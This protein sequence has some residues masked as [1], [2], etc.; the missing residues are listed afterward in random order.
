[1]SPLLIGSVVAIIGGSVGPL[2]GF[3]MN[4]ARYLGPKLFTFFAD[5]D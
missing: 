5:W 2:T 1:M 3:A 4:P